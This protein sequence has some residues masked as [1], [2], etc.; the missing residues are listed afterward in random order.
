MPVSLIIKNDNPIILFANW[1]VATSTY[2]HTYLDAVSSN[3]TYIHTVVVQY[4]IMYST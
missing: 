3:S 2:I 1:Y 4:S